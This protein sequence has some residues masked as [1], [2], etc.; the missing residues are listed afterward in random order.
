MAVAVSNW[1]WIGAVCGRSRS[2]RYLPFIDS[3]IRRKDQ[4]TNMMS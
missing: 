1:W 4:L 3:D 2:H